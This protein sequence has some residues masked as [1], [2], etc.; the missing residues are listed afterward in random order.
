MHIPVLLQEVVSGLQAKN[1]EVILDATVGDG[2][3]SEALCRAIGKNAS[4]QDSGQTTFICLD[5]DEDAINRS[6]QR[7]KDCA[8]GQDWHGCKFFFERTNYRKLDKALAGFGFRGISRALFDLG[9]SSF[10]LEE[11]GRG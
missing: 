9:L 7:L 1:G 6:R 11:S 2:G 5:A 3:H 10:Q 4:R 8:R